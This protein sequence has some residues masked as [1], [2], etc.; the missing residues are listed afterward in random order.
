MSDMD[1]DEFHDQIQQGL[2]K[3]FARLNERDQ[4]SHSSDKSRGEPLASS[5]PMTSAAENTPGKA[6]CPMGEKDD[7]NRPE[8]EEDGIREEQRRRM[9]VRRLFK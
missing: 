8:T 7:P 4:G 1:S 5:S 2:T 6:E 9:R 3:L